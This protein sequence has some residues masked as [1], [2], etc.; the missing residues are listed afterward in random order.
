[1]RHTGKLN[2][3]ELAK[4]Q[5]LE[6][7]KSVSRK[8]AIRLSRLVDDIE[9]F[10]GDIEKEIG[11]GRLRA[12]NARGYLSDIYGEISDEQ[13]LSAMVRLAHELGKCEPQ[14]HVCDEEG[15]E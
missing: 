2:P 14:C 3:E 1:M 4:L 12:F 13:W 10:E 11:G 15:A 8:I 5:R 6:R 9:A 7:M